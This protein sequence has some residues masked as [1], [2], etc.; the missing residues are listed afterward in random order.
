MTF[1]VGGCRVTIGFLFLAVLAL[2]L[3]LDRSGIALVG[4]ACAALHESAHLIAMGLTGERPQEMHFTV[5]GIDL[6]KSCQE[7]R[8]YQKDIL[9]SLAGPIA[10]LAAAALCFFVFQQQFI[11]FLAANLL[12][13]ALNI[14]PIVPLD[15]GQALISLLCLHMEPE[16]AVK[17]V[18]IISFCVLVPLAAVGFFVLLRSRWNFTLLFVACYLMALLLMKKDR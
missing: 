2:L 5:F 8:S 9:V 6:I 13:F 3:A 11:L 4:I 14:L 7:A 10:N 1:T 15:G 17:I 18:S 12:L 16:K